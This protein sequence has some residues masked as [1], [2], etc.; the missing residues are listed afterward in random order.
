M[1]RLEE[2]I[3]SLA[4]VIVRYHDSQD[5]RDKLVVAVDPTALKKKSHERAIEI[6]Q[7]T[8][9]DY[10]PYLEGR[11]SACTKGYHGREEFLFF[12]L[13]EIRFLKEQLDRKTPFEEK[14]LQTFH[15]QLTQLFIDFRQ[16]LNIKKGFKHSATL[17][18]SK[19]AK[20]QELSGL[21]ND[22]MI[23]GKYCNSG[24]LLIEE[25]LF[26]LHM[27][28]EDSNAELKEIASNICLEHQ[29]QLEN[30]REK[31]KKANEDSEKEINKS[32]LDK[33]KTS[34]EVQKSESEAQRLEIEKLKESL[35]MHK[36]ESEAHILELQETNKKQLVTIEQLTQELEKTK[37][38]LQ[39]AQTEALIRRYP[40]YNPLFGLAG[41]QMLQRQGTNPQTGTNRFFPSIQPTNSPSQTLST[42][43]E[44]EESRHGSTIE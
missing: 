14:E 27:T 21:L 38:E 30:Q 12:V 43:Q 15:E 8:K 26:V 1:T 2:L 23:G 3:Y 37:T 35:E 4:T 29:T 16:L 44:A 31:L 42:D 41:L 19:G 24:Q 7:D 34:S 22:R 20:T 32:E 18:S 33:L 13:N 11:I 10:F 28:T 5:I 25:V 6:I 40:T 17:N 9:I 36:S 39:K